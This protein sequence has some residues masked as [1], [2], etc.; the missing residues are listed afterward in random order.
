MILD[1]INRLSNLT[2]IEIFEFIDNVKEITIHN[3]NLFVSKTKFNYSA[4]IL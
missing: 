1:E 3:H 4:K 2:K